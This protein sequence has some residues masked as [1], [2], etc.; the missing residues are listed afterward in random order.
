MNEFTIYP[1][2]DLRSGRVVRLVQGD[3]KRQ[4]I[5]GDDP[6]EM[7]RRWV[8][9]GASWLHIVNLDGAF[10]EPDNQNRTGLLRIMRAMES[11][12]PPPGI[13]LGGGLRS[14]TDIEQAVSLGISRVIL[15]TAAV[16]SP[17]LLQAAIERFSSE[18]VAVA[19]DVAGGRVM[20]RGWVQE[21]EIEP[22]ALCQNLVKIGVEKII[23]TDISRDGTGAGLNLAAACT[24]SEQTGLYVIVSGGVKSLEDIRQAKASGLSGVIIGRALYDGAISLPEALAC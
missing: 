7:A 8:N 23:Y 14:M 22:L 15:G 3:P 2:I 1:A 13:Q 18:K 16:K 24:I 10:E 6:A 19:L 12:H 20:L 21:E 11:I 17:A 4:T 9:G 5:F